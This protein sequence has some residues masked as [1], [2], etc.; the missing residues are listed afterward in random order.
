MNWAQAF[1]RQA[2]SDL[3][4]RE[5]L[6]RQAGLPACHALHHLQMACEKICKASMIA[7][8]TPPTAV[9]ESHAYI[10]KQLPIIVRQY[11]NR[12]DVGKSKNNWIVNAVRSL[13]RKI[14]LLSPAVRDGGRSPQNC[15]YPWLGADG[16]TVIA[17]SDHRF[18]FSELFEPAGTTLLKILRSAIEDLQK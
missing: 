2:E 4:A 9:Q 5:I 18:D 6:V 11:L 17:P 1:A 15:E 16:T 12:A 14:E 10:A 7:S 13:A 8:G 3:N